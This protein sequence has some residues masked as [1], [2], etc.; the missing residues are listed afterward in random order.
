VQVCFKPKNTASPAAPDT[1]FSVPLTL[2]RYGLSE[3]V[4]HLLTQVRVSGHENE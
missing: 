3:I 2:N 1:F 4:N